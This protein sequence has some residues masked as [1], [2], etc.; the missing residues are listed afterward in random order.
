LEYKWSQ[1]GVKRRAKKKYIKP[2]K[3]TVLEFEPESGV[4]P[5]NYGV[6]PYF[7]TET[8]QVVPDT[9]ETPTILIQRK[10]QDIRNT[11]QCFF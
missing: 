4:C 10:I 3:R 7:Q 5:L 11:N 9:E 2:A 8:R 6:T 1:K